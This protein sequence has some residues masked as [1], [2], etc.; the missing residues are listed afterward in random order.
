MVAR[1]L[2][3]RKRPLEALGRDV[4]DVRLTSRHSG[5]LASV[6]VPRDDVLP[7]FRKRHHTRQ[8]HISEPNHPTKHPETP[9]PVP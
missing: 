4:L 1:G 5:G 3:A 9:L 8:A 6:D 7:R 2:D